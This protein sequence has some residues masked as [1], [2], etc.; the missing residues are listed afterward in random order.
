M[1]IHFYDT[2]V[3]SPSTG[4]T[5]SG[6]IALKS[7][8]LNRYWFGQERYYINAI[9]SHNAFMDLPMCCNTLVAPSKVNRNLMHVKL[10]ILSRWLCTTRPIVQTLVSFPAV[11]LFADH[12]AVHNVEPALMTPK[13]LISPWQAFNHPPLSAQPDLMYMLKTIQQYLPMTIDLSPLS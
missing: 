1:H 9:V 5:K 2:A 12:T 3:L 7:T 4:E 6:S 8:E 10:P 13:P 11:C